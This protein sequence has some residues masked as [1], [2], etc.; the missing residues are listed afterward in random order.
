LME[1]SAGRRCE[2]WVAR[3]GERVGS[4]VS[5][6][7]LPGS[8]PSTPDDVLSREHRARPSCGTNPSPQTHL[9]K[10]G[11]LTESAKVIIAA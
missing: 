2:E 4:G 9:L 1:R 6:L 11:L 5:A 3:R 7:G 8:A 10:S